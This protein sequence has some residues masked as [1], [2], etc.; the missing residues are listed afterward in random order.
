MLLN[1]VLPGTFVLLHK[2]FDRCGVF[3]RTAA[4]ETEVRAQARPNVR[5]G[6]NFTIRDVENGRVWTLVTVK[7]NIDL[8]LGQ[9][10]L[11]RV[12]MGGSVTLFRPWEWNSGAWA[13]YFTLESKIEG[14]SLHNIHHVS[15]GNET[16]NRVWPN[17]R[18]GPLLS[19][20]QFF[21]NVMLRVVEDVARPGLR[22]TRGILLQWSRN[23]HLIGEFNA[24][25]L[26]TGLQDDS[27]QIRGDLVDGRDCDT[28][29]L[30]INL[31][32]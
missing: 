31:P 12:G 15:T 5:P 32:Q 19:L 16:H 30:R 26:A 7:G 2:F 3:C 20:R 22:D 14:D 21:Q 27:F 11:E 28:D 24:I 23:G 13:I 9:N 1:Q 10:I 25:T 8:H 4:L 29:K 6:Y 17:L 18:E